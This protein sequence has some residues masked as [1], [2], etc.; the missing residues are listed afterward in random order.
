MATFGDLVVRLGLDKTGF[1]RGIS[2]TRKVLIGTATAVTG[3]AA[4]LT[5]AGLALKAFIEPAF[6]SL[7]RLGDLSNRLGVATDKLAAMQYAAKLSG[8]EQESL[9]TS[10]G[11]FLNTLSDASNGTKSAVS[12]FKALGLNARQLKTLELDQQFA[13]LADA[14]KAIENPADRVRMAM[15]L[16]GKSGAEMLQLLNGGAGQLIETLDEAR[17]LGIAPTNAEVARIQS[18]NDAL[19]RMRAA[20]DGI[21]NT[22]A[23]SVAPTVQALLVNVGVMTDALRAAITGQKFDIAA[24]IKANVKPFIAAMKADAV[25]MIRGLPKM[26]GRQSAPGAPEEI[27]PGLP[28]PQGI[29]G[30]I[31]RFGS[32][33]TPSTI[34]SG[35]LGIGGNGAPGGLLAALG[36]RVA[37]A[38]SQ[39]APGSIRGSSE[40][41]RHIIA[42]GQ[43]GGDPGVKVAEQQLAQQKLQTTALQALVK[44]PP[45]VVVGTI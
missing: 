39:I 9:T 17:R 20:W 25:N 36:R 11:R 43:R 12:A 21:A 10:V 15:D 40:A 24:S 2:S 14:F 30:G 42:A 22:L 44:N 3:M 6:E 41:L 35:A 7:D 16:F 32:G 34:G 23:I 38:S 27:A 4:A 28:I 31:R 19:D 1:D 13:L 45:S 33:L 5:G 18:A 8:I 26:G 37:S 29:G